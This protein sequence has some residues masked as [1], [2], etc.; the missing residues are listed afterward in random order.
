MEM[1]FKM[2]CHSYFVQDPPFRLTNRNRPMEVSDTLFFKTHT[3]TAKVFAFASG[4]FGAIGHPFSLFL[5]GPLK[6]L[7][8]AYVPTRLYTYIITDQVLSKSWRGMKAMSDK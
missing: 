7:Y 2:V 3:D 4:I 1:G 6:L 5:Y 8:T